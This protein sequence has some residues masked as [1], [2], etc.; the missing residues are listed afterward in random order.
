VIA[1]ITGSG[2]ASGEGIT[3]STRLP[4]IAFQSDGRDR[5][6]FSDWKGKN[7]VSIYHIC[8]HFRPRLNATR[9]A[10]LHPRRANILALGYAIL[11]SEQKQ[12]PQ[13]ASEPV[14]DQ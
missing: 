10:A 5:A 2:L 4:N 3:T 8:A 11:V 7:G 12:F 13:F 1:R 6:V 9:S 14:Y